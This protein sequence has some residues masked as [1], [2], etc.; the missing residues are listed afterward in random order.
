MGTDMRSITN[1]LHIQEFVSKMN[2]FT[3]AHG[4]VVA[5]L[6]SNKVFLKDN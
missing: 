5:L 3:A 6:P 2:M 1:H 4:Y